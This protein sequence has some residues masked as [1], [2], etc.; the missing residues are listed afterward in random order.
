MNTLREI[1][2]QPEFHSLPIL[3]LTAKAMKGRPGKMSGGRSVG[4]HRQTGQRRP[5]NF[6]VA[7]LAVSRD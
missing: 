3:A 4:L 7:R 2:K 1:R 6:V 5:A